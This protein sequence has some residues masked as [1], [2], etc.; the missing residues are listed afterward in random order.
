[1]SSLPVSR[2]QALVA[3]LVLLSL[4]AVAGR[5]LAGAGAST[6]VVQP[7]LMPEAAG[8]AP[9]LVVHVTGAVARPGLYR[10]KEGSRV[11]DAV[12][13]AGGAT[14]KADTAAVNLAAPLADGIQ[15]LMPSRVAGGAGAAAAAGGSGAGGAGSGVP[16]SLSSATIAELDTL[17]GVGPVTAQKIV[18]HRAAHG[19]FSSVDDL[20]AIPGIG[21]ARLGQLRGLV[22]P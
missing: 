6:P 22:T 16:I 4:L 9:R 21:P 7:A 11:A 18:D 10:L 19:A 1:M 13:R 20:D 12:A 8:V 5:T 3:A 14:G 15:V 2:R 17:P